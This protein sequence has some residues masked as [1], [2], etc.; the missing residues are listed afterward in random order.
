MHDDEPFVVLESQLRFQFWRSF[1]AFDSKPI[2]NAIL[3]DHSLRDA[4]SDRPH[5]VALAARRRRTVGR[6]IIRGEHR[7]RAGTTEQNDRYKRQ[8]TEATM[9][10]IVFHN[11]LPSFSFL[12]LHEI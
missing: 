10:L 5:V 8:P 2:L 7:L 9:P 3:A 4:E 1:A 11:I 6:A 12:G